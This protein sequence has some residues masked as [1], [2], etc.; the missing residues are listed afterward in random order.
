MKEEDGN[1]KRGGLE[2]MGGW[3]FEQGRFILLVKGSHT[4]CT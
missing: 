2:N 3:V 1:E 4:S